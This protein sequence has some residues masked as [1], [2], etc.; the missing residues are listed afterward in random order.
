MKHLPSFKERRFWLYVSV[1]LGIFAIFGSSSL[2]LN[3][4]ETGSI[5]FISKGI[6][7]S[8]KDALIAQSV[9]LVCGVLFVAMG[10]I[11]IKRIYKE[12][13]NDKT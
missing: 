1:V 4:H 5:N 7:I 3:Y 2:L 6:L 10:L 11:G 8:G 13:K 9:L 12:E